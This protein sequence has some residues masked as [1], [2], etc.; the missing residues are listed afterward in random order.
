MKKAVHFVVCMFVF[1]VAVFGQPYPINLSELSEQE[2]VYTMSSGGDSLGYSKITIS[3]FNNQWTV[4]EKAHVK[5]SFELEEEMTTYLN[6][7]LNWDSVFV[8]GAFNVT[9]T[10]QSFSRVINRKITAE[11]NYKHL[12][13]K[14]FSRLDTIINLPVIERLTSL[15]LFPS[16][17]NFTKKDDYQYWQFNPTDCEFRMVTVTKTSDE[18][19]DT[20]KGKVETYRLEFSGGVAEQVLFITK[21]LPKRIVRIEFKDSDWVYT[22]N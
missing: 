3:H 1:N 18:I 21:E 2:L 14:E 9:K 16:L 22:L 10:F 20:S 11:S 17:I 7:Q 13:G 15:F 12:V 4:S 5:S 8:K 6:D 19:I